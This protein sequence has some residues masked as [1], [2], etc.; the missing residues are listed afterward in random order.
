MS[1]NP[2]V[3]VI[4]FGFKPRGTS[5]T[6]MTDFRHEFH[7]LGGALPGNMIRFGRQPVGTGGGPVVVAAPVNHPFFATVGRLMSR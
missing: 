4:R 6:A 3:N 7:R 5:E 1:L 2:L